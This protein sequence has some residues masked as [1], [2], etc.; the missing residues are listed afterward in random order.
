MLK[1]LHTL[2]ASAPSAIRSD[3]GVIAD[4]DQ[5]IVDGFASGKPPAIEE[6]PELKAAMLHEALWVQKNCS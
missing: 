3:L 2:A 1:R 4:F 6:T 5:K